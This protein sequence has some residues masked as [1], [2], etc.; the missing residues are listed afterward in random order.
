MAVWMTKKNKLSFGLPIIAGLITILFLWASSQVEKRTLLPL[1]TPA[2]ND[3]KII[4]PD[5]SRA[6]TELFAAQGYEL[7]GV[8]MSKITVPRLYVESL[9]QD[10]P[11]LVDVKKRKEIFLQTVL[12]LA[13]AVNEELRSHQEALQKIRSLSRP[14]T[15]E[16]LDWL[17]KISATHKITHPDLERLLKQ[18]APLP[19][20]LILAQAAVESGWGTSRFAL[21]G[22]ALFG[23]WTWK[24]GAGIIPSG[25]G[26]GETHAVRAYPR[27]IDSV[28]DYANNLN[29]S[30]AYKDFRDARARRL[31]LGKPLAGLPLIETLEKYSQ[32]GQDYLEVLEDIIEQNDLTPLNNAQLAGDKT[33]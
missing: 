18:I 28:W 7:R 24:P 4:S 10:L 12:P 22:N 25:R 6:L 16:E 26:D 15:T 2:F 8:R 1:V 29:T 30:L 20:E 14:L 33:D 19:V 27:L 17:N 31:Q 21:E 5:T 23:Q 32:K 11:Q 13:L 3:G 9:P